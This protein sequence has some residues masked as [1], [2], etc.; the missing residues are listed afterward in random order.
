MQDGE[1]VT[2]LMDGLFVAPS[3]RELHLL[4]RTAL[5][6]LGL[7]PTPGR[8]RKMTRELMGIARQLRTRLQEDEDVEG[9]PRWT[10]LVDDEEE[11]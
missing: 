7:T 8:M 2:R 1:R 11:E 10:I 4:P 3:S 6:M 5:E 9:V